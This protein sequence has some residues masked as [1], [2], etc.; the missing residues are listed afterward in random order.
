M[1][2]QDIAG[3]NTKFSWLGVSTLVEIEQ[4]VLLLND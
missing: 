1:N 4:Y 2:G 3:R